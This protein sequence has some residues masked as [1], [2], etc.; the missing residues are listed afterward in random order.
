MRKLR[1]INGYLV[2]RF[3]EVERNG[4]EGLGTYGI[5]DAELYTGKLGIDIGAMEYSDAETI[6]QAAEQAQGLD[7]VFEGDDL[8]KPTEVGEDLVEQYKVE[9]EA[10]IESNHFFPDVCPHTAR[11]RLHGYMCG[12][13]DCGRLEAGQVV[14]PRE[15]FE[16]PADTFR[17]L[18]K[19]SES[20][21]KRVFALGLALE[22][23]CP[24]NDCKIFLELFRMCRALDEQIGRLDSYPRAAME[25]QLRRQYSELE[26]YYLTNYAVQEYRRE[27]KKPP[28]KQA[29][30]GEGYV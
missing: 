10:Q 13:R 14:V 12:L 25:R 3:N 1:K 30:E 23:G 11:H 26:G 27:L 5:I 6:E 2:V 29:A 18:V 19:S 16:A 20:I 8:L 21:V 4:M 22:H 24:V 28:E 7:A 15:L 17:H 9:L